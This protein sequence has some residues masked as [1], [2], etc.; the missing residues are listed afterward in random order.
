YE[1]I[2]MLKAELAN[3]KLIVQFGGGTAPN[4]AGDRKRLTQVM[5]N[6]LSNAIKF[7]PENET[8]DIS[9]NLDNERTVVLSIAD[10]GPGVDRRDRRRIFGKF[11]QTESGVGKGT[12]LGLAIA[13]R[14]VAHHN[15]KIGMSSRAGGGSIFW[16]RL[17]RSE[18]QTPDSDR[19]A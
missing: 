14:I 11:E 19:A 15:G 3:K 1:T 9:V 16:V 12:G 2:D 8:I 7:S 6:L 4:V 18:A 17:Q 5:L 10:R 13:K